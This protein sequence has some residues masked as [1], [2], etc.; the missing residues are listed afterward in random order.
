MGAGRLVWLWIAMSAVWGA[1]APTNLARGKPATQSSVFGGT[2]KDQGPQ[3]AVDGITEYAGHEFNWFHTNLEDHPWW[4]VDLGQLCELTEVRIFNRLLP[5]EPSVPLRARTVQVQLSDDG[6]RWTRLYAHDGKPFEVLKV[7][8]AGARARYVRLELRERNYFHLREV[9]VDG[10]PAAAV[11]DPGA[12]TGGAPPPRPPAPPAGGPQQKLTRQGVSVMA[13]AALR[14]PADALQVAPPRKRPAAQPPGMA[15]VGGHDV[16]LGDRHAFDEPLTIEFPLRRDQVDAK[17]PPGRGVGAAT[18]DEATLRWVAV[19]ARYDAQRQVLRLWTR[20][21][22]TFVY[23]SLRGYI[24]L[25]S[26]DQHFYVYYRPSVIP[27][28]RAGAFTTARQAAEEVALYL[29]DAWDRYEQAGLTMPTLL[30]ELGASFEQ[31]G[32]GGP[33]LMVDAVL[34]ENETEPFYSG[35]GRNLMIACG[36]PYDNRNELHHACAHEFF[37]RIENGYLSRFTNMPAYLWWIEMMADAAAS[38][39]ACPQLGEAGLNPFTAGMFLEPMTYNADTHAYPYARWWLDLV[40]Q[41]VNLVDLWERSVAS[42][43]TFWGGPL[44]GI[45]QYVEAAT[46]SS[47]PVHWTTYS[48]RILFGAGSTIHRDRA[49]THLVPPAIGASTQ[50]GRVAR[51]TRPAQATIALQAPGGYSAVAHTLYA[52]ALTG[53]GPT[54]NVGVRLLDPLPSRVDVQVFRLPGSRLLTQQVP[55]AFLAQG[56]MAGPFELRN[57]TDLRAADVLCL[58][59]HNASAQAA[60][61]RVEAELMPDPGGFEFGLLPRYSQRERVVG[62]GDQDITNNYPTDQHTFYSDRPSPVVVRPDGTFTVDHRYVRSE[63]DRD[64]R[65]DDMLSVKATGRLSPDRQRV[66]EATV[67]SRLL[68]KMN[69]GSSITNVRVLAQLKD[70]TLDRPASAAGTRRY[71]GTAGNLVRLELSWEAIEILPNGARKTRTYTVQ[72]ITGGDYVLIFNEQAPR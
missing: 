55:E 54:C 43:G 32:L 48:N 12:P 61:L 58:V 4:Q 21:L 72:E 60:Q 6:Q 37:H 63:E 53:N 2:G 41:G 65:D 7:P 10:R 29:D 50:L 52:G 8:A 71:K 3:L 34:V 42:T 27:P 70:L 22:S 26:P 68:G 56:E 33:Q 19:P 18:W 16:S 47:L 38:G 23:W 5:G 25:V 64:P 9:E 49:G 69:D 66:L 30:G 24:Y 45:E 35:L 40:G 46:G 31:V 15:L 36:A 11:A 39:I 59:V 1:E 14:L 44:T 51:F 62:P 17:L 57:A 67:E 20:H 28:L 13:P